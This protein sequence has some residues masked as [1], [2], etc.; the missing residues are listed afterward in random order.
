[1]SAPRPYETDPFHPPSSAG[2][3]EDSFAWNEQTGLK[4]TLREWFSNNCRK[5]SRD[6][7]GFGFIGLSHWF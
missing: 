5:Q 7:F 3:L 1:M 2:S 6:C 4:S